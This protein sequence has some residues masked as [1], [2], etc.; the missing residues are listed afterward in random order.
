MQARR[1][2][3]FRGK[4]IYTNL[5]R[6]TGVSYIWMISEVDLYYIL[7]GKNLLDG[8]YIGKYEVESGSVGNSLALTTRTAGM[9]T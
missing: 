9:A 7:T 5:Y 4:R 3:K 2:I 6:R 8:V 1:E